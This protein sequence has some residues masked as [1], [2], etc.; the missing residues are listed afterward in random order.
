MTTFPYLKSSVKKYTVSQNAFLPRFVTVPLV[1]EHGISCKPVVQVGN[2]VHEGQVIAIPS[3]KYNCRIHSP[4]PG[5]VTE[6]FTG[7]S[8]SGRPE[9]MIKI[10]MSGNFSYTGKRRKE[11]E[12]QKMTPEAVCEMMVENGV[13]NLFNVLNPQSLSFQI[14]NK[15]P[16]AHTLVVR[17]FDEDPVR[18]TDSFIA[19]NMISEVKK[20]AEITAYAAGMKNIVYVFD[21]GVAGD[22]IEINPDEK[23]LFVNTKKNPCCFPKEICAAYRRNNKKNPETFITEEDLFV[24]STT[25]YEVYKAVGLG[26]PGI[27][28]I[29]QFTGNCLP[30]KCML[31][32]RIGTTFNEVVSQIGGF[33]KEPHLL[34]INGHLAGNSVFSGF[35]PV[36]KYVKSVSFV[37]RKRTPEQLV[38]S[39]ISCG[40]C[41]DNCPRGLAPDLLYKYKSDNYP[42]PEKYAETAKHCAGCGLCNSV[43]PSRIPLTQIIKVLKDSLD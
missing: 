40:Y 29:V 8:A 25:M 3:G 34:I 4:V 28:H 2:Y 42:L 5:T 26:I 1:Q 43:C 31:N 32:V 39:C 14:H 6:I 19:L 35:V 9:Q 15:S 20:G 10:A 38:N 13:V 21:S 30:S 36:T 16:N 27:D 41:R 37:S 22:S 17:M 23:H 24:D 7:V 33:L 11:T 18:L 12:W